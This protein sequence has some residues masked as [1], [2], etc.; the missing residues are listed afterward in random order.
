[1][2]ERKEALQN[3]L[4]K[5][6]VGAGIEYSAYKKAF[7]HPD[8]LEHEYGKTRDKARNA[9]MGSQDAVQALHDAVLSE[10]RWSLYEEDDGTFLC[11]VSLRS[12]VKIYEE[13]WAKTPSMARLK[14]I[15][16]AL[17]AQEGE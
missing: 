15:I 5:V 12:N 17:I 3:L 2:S 14:A 4:V 10:Y 9:F 1:M 6:E 16:K 7:P 8:D 13:E 11:M